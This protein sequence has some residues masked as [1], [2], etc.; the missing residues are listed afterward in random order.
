MTKHTGKKY[1]EGKPKAWSF[2]TNFPLALQCVAELDTIGAEKYSAGGWREV[3]DG[4]QRY[5]EAFSRHTL[6]LAAGEIYDEGK[7]GTG[8]PHKAAM[9]WNLLCTLELELESGEVESDAR[10]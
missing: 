1:D 6:K 10:G 8:K 4:E 2:I 5:M 9:L 7:D 3:E